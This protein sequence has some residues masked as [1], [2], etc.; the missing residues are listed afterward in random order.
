MPKTL[1][2]VGEGRT[3]KRNE[4]A[5]W[6][7]ERSI[8]LS[9]APANPATLVEMFDVVTLEYHDSFEA[10]A[11]AVVPEDQL[12]AGRISQHSEIGKAILGC[13]LGDEVDIAVRGG[14]VA[15]ITDIKKYDDS[16]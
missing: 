14:R 8:A 1:I 7:A 6:P 4:E 12:A 2:R 10:V 11:I 3:Q 9:K 15:Q 5:S 13:R 16:E